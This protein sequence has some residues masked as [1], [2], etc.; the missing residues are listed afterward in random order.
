MDERYS[1]DT[2]ICLKRTFTCCNVL[3]VILGCLY[4]SAGVMCPAMVTSYFSINLGILTILIGLMGTIPKVY[5]ELKWVYQV[6]RAG[7]SLAFLGLIAFAFVL[8]LYLGKNVKS[9]RME[10]EKR[11]KGFTKYQDYQDWWN[12]AQRRIRCCG[13]DNYTDWR[14][15]GG[16]E[17]TQIVP[18][19]CC[20]GYSSQTA[21][22]ECRKNPDSSDLF[23]E[24]C[25]EKRR[26]IRIYKVFF[27][28]SVNVAIACLTIVAIIL[29]TSLYRH[30]FEEIPSST[31]IENAKTKDKKNPEDSEVVDSPTDTT[32][33]PRSKPKRM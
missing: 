22:N 12:M 13:V 5:P 20:K 7:M 4:L 33:A 3:F 25:L 10:M 6:Y 27:G 26:K 30:Y 32:K 18:S 9:D 31:L 14:G 28:S 21:L 17:G 23:K 8:L 29:A 19:S 1:G 24:G 15:F 2:L 16:F 11:M